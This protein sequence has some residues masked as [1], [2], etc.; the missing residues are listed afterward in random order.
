M[1]LH[2]SDEELSQRKRILR[3]LPQRTLDNLAR[4]DGDEAAANSLRSSWRSARAA[5]SSSSSS[6]FASKKQLPLTERFKA[7]KRITDGG[8]LRLWLARRLGACSVA[9]LFFFSTLFVCIDFVGETVEDVAHSL[10]L[11]NLTVQTWCKLPFQF[12]SFCDSEC[13]FLNYNSS[14]AL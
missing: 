9:A 14:I 3:Q 12:T 2:S 5:S 10:N 13:L 8:M 7:V 11:A 4:M 6:A 1:K